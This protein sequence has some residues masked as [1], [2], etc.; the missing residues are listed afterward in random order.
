MKELK[1]KSASHSD[2]SRIDNIVYLLLYITT[3]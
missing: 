1:H 3:A 2:T